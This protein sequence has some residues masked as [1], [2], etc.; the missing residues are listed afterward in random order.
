MKIINL[1][2]DSQIYTSNVYLITGTWNAL[3][4]QNTLVDVGRD[5]SIIEKIQNA[6][7]GVGKRKLDQVILTHSHYDHAS[8]SEQ[9][10]ESFSPRIYA[11]SNSQKY[12]DTILR[13][14]ERLRIGDRL[15]EVI[16]TPGHTQDSIC[17]YCD[18][19][20]VLFVGD[21][22]V[23]IRVPGSTYDEKFVQALLSIAERDVRAIYFGHGRPMLENCNAVIRNSIMNMKKSRAVSIHL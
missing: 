8:L 20:G 17:L 6:R 19:D 23:I 11:F 15:F 18:E 3:D 14:G 9:I 13:G 1:T 21:T 4:D 5:P 22:P 12:V 7:T 2:E 10:K 16:H